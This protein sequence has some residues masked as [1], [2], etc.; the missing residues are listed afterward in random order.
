[1]HQHQ[2]QIS[3]EVHEDRSQRWRYFGFTAVVGVLLLLNLAGTIKT[4][5]GVDTAAIL[6]LVAGY[7]T[8]YNAISGLL[9]KRISADLASDCAAS[10]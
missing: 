2:L 8:F 6:A 5:F 4:V 10:G 1:M 9:E 7:R 3:T